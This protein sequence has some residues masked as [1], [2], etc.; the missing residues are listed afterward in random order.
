MATDRQRQ[1]GQAGSAEFWC[2]F[3]GAVTEHGIATHFERCIGASA[4]DAEHSGGGY[5]V[6]ASLWAARTCVIL[7]TLLGAYILDR[8]NY[9]AFIDQERV[10]VTRQ[11]AVLRARLEGSI[12]ENI[13]T[14]RGLVAVIATEPAMD[15]PRFAEIAEVVLQDRQELRN[16]AAAPDMV[17]R[18]MYPLAGNEEAVGLDYRSNAA[19]WPKVKQAA[20]SGHLVLAGPV[21]LVQGGQGFIGRVPVFSRS[22]DRVQ[23]RFWGLVSAVID[24][25]ALYQVAGLN[26]VGELRVALRR[27][28]DEGEP[29]EVFFGDAQIFAQSPTVLPVPV[30]GGL[31]EIAAVP[32]G[33]WPSQADNVVKFRSLLVG[34]ASLILLP[35]IWLTVSIQRARTS[36]QRLQALFELSPMGMALID[37]RTGNFVQLNQALLTMSGFAASRLET[38]GI[39][40]ILLEPNQGYP[41]QG[42][43]DGDRFGPLEF[44]CLRQRGEPLPVLLAGVLLRDASG[45]KLVWAV[46]QDIAEQKRVERMKSEFVAT[47]SHELRTPLTSIA[48]ALKLI[49]E[50]LLGE[51]PEKA[52]QMVGIAQ[53]NSERL[54][55]LINDLLDMDKLISGKMSFQVRA[56]P[57]AVLMKSSLNGISA[58]AQDHDVVLKY[59][60]QAGTVTVRT[61]EIRFQQVMD[62]LLSNAIKFSPA[63]GQVSVVATQS[64]REV[65]IAVC[66]QG[67]GIPEA[68]HGYIF[69]KFAQADGSD[70]RVKGGTGLGL[71]ITRGLLQQMDGSI[72]FETRAG[73]GTCFYITLPKA[74]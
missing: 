12:N 37:R 51:L 40:Q 69:E 41:W 7:A 28:G 3:N 15:Q 2:C 22:Q 32:S 55:H 35:G 58:Y 72:R 20:E 34:A 42:L 66:D 44:Q 43:R 33:G 48:G 30:A 16:I 74:P 17:I 9:Q 4:K 21:N 38:K 36:Q 49:S 53:K 47:V 19:Q 54:T 31:W 26:D 27:T 46:V 13:Q 5:A 45:S 14:I 70:R 25:P 62:N 67:P 52:Q 23:D 11:L 1:A 24:V 73:E 57:L 10:D 59:D 61:D 65:Q 56:C 18:L 39:G 6:R 8:Q 63:G 68:F 50:G 60:N 64:D 71:A 29:A